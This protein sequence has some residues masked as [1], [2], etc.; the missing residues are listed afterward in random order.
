MQ[1]YYVGENSKEKFSAKIIVIGNTQ[2]GKTSIL[3]RY[4]N[5]VFSENNEYVTIGKLKLHPLIISLKGM[6][7]MIKILEIDN[8]QMKLEFWDTAGQE[9]FRSVI[10]QYY[11]DSQGAVVVFD[12]SNPKSFNELKF[13]VQQLRDF[14]DP[15]VIKLLLGN[16]SDMLNEK[17]ISQEEID[18]F[19]NA[20]DFFYYETSAKLN[21]N[22]D[23]GFSE[24]AKQIKDRFYIAK[25]NSYEK[26]ETLVKLRESHKKIKV[27]NG[28]DE[29]CNC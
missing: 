20:N 29:R 8:I 4:I 1:E 19:C 13:W 18:K 6:D 23:D 17:R 9:R 24:L 28:E 5:N 22:I 25:K 14:A 21:K 27:A 15:G 7:Y 11:N 12:L 10:Q 16:K 3:S 2:V 26:N